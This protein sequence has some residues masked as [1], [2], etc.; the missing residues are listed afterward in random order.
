[1]IGIARAMVRRNIAIE[2]SVQLPA[3]R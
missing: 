2:A 1:M 3:S